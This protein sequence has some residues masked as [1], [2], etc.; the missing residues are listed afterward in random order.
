MIQHSVKWGCDEITDT[1]W[2]KKVSGW[3]VRVLIYLMYL[4]MIT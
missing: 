2:E 3:V 4:W 1:V